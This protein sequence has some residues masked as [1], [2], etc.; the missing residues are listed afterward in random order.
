MDPERIAFVGVSDLSGHFRGKSFPIADLAQRLERGVGLAP[1]NIMMSAFGPIHET[2][3]GTAGEVLLIPD[4]KTRVEVEFDDGP[5]EIFFC[6]DVVTL[7]GAPWDGCPRGFLKG[8]L[9]ALEQEAG[10]RLFSAFEQEL[11]YTG[12][13]GTPLPYTLD[14]LRR[15]GRFGE[16]LLAALR[17]GGITPDSFLAEYGPGQYEVT[18]KPAIGVAAADHA[19]AVR[20]LARAAAFRLGHRAIF[21]P[22]LTPDGVGNGTHIHFSLLN[23]DGAPAMAD[24]TRPYG[25]S[26]LGEHFVAGILKH[27]P[28]LAAVT[29]PSVASYYRLRPGRWAPTEASLASV[30][31]GAGLR[32]CA[33]IGDDEASR[34][35]QFNVEYRVADAAASPH[36][37][38]GALVHAG[39]EG[40]RKAM[41]LPAPGAASAGDPLPGSLA[42]ALD[43]L[44]A[45]AC[46]RAW[47]GPVLF[48]LYLGLKRAEVRALQGLDEAEI[49]RRYANV[50]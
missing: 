42:D 3:F 30:D 23:A 4:P 33:M 37:A 32:I 5:P 39:V 48:D 12:V 18:V 36:L 20:E 11:V 26:K 7:E 10:L 35:G 29:A 21:A 31:R 22:I 13:S 25:L 40:I 6:G 8:G 47:F 14:A 45:S 15:Q 41:T 19:V 27:L 1:S 9:E 38:L 16:T 24:P 2:P 17:Q 49:C 44:A 46:A 28:V 34:R 43:G 50:Y